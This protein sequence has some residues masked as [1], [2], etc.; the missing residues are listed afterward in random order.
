MTISIA[1]SERYSCD[2]VSLCTTLHRKQR[3]RVKLQ[4]EIEAPTAAII[5][6][7]DDKRELYPKSETR[8]WP[9]WTFRTGDHS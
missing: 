6:L 1:K 7:A 8:P 5:L 2:P 3:E 9:L 4:R